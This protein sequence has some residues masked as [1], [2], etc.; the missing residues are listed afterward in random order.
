VA[1]AARGARAVRSLLELVAL[2]ELVALGEGAVLVPVGM[3]V[4][5]EMAA[6]VQLA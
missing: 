3:Q 6:A 4:L 2:V 1:V 5:A